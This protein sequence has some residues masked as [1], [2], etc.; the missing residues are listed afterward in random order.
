MYYT[1]LTMY[2]DCFA[3][4][5]LFCSFRPLLLLILAML[6]YC[7]CNYMPEQQSVYL[8]CQKR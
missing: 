8:W 5:V 2:N 4:S 7:N 1:V 6:C 3:L